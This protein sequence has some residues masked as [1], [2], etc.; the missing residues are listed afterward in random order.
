MIFSAPSGEIALTSFLT[1]DSFLPFY[2]LLGELK[3]ARKFAKTRVL[4]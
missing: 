4:N 3:F 2:F 1:K